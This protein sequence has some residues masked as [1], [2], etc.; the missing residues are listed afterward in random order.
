M[1]DNSLFRQIDRI[2]LIITKLEDEINLQYLESK[3]LVE[4]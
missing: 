4:M 1:I 2:R 3:K